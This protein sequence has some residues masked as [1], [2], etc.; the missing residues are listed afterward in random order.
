MKNHRTSRFF[1]YMIAIIGIITYDIY[2]QDLANFSASFVD[3]GFGARPLGMGQA[4]T[5]LTADANGVL[6]NPAGI[7]EVERFEGTF[8]H[9]KLFNIVP[10]SFASLVYSFSPRLSLGEG[11]II[12]GDDLLRELSIISCLATSFYVHGYKLNLGLNLNLHSASYGKNDDSHSNVH[13]DAFGYSLGFGLQLYLTEKIIFASNFKNIINRISWNSSTM[14]KY[15]EG[16]PGRLIF[17]VGFKNFN[18][19]NFALD[20]HKSLYREIEDKFFL[21]AEYIFFDKL[22]LRSGTGTSINQSQPLFYSVG[23]GLSHQFNPRFRFQ[24]DGAYII[25]P[26]AN[27]I[28]LSILVGMK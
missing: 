20:F 28:R 24:L 9:T 8:C 19:L 16:L 13:G 21:G 26:L 4:Y 25:D 18:Q 6:W 3:I 17:G 23:F 10:Y 2:S 14:G 12:S 11:V 5:A 27:M 22:F 7:S 1:L 15:D